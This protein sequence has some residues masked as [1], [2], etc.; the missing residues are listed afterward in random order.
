L[1]Q[2]IKGKALFF[3][4]REGSFTQLD[5]CGLNTVEDQMHLKELV[6]E[7]PGVSVD[8]HGG[9]QNHKPSVVNIKQ[10]SEMNQ[11]IYKAK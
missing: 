4:S 1:E 7:V 2:K 11:R 5:V 10:S 3:L 8:A 6:S 9:R